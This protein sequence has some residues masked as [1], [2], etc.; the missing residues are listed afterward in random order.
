[1]PENDPTIEHYNALMNSGAKS[2]MPKYRCHKTVH[3]MKIDKIV[4]PTPPGN[5]SDGSRILVCEGSAIKADW[6]YMRK[7]KPEVG[8]YY[9]VYDD[10]YKSF[11]PAKA[12]EDG[13]TRI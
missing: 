8:G 3:A 1:M 2:E 5:E 7:H 12:F 9:V 13:Y 10:G 4:D 11:S 6:D